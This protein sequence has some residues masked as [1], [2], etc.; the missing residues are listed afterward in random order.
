MSTL[1][2]RDFPVELHDKVK[3]LAKKSHRSVSAEITVLVDKAL[4]DEEL[5]EQRIEALK[6]IEERRMSYVKTGKEV[7][8][9]ILL[10]EDR[11]R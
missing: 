8:S 10:R 5:K 11:E 1:Y 6:R 9:L 7:D 2:V 4:K 3:E